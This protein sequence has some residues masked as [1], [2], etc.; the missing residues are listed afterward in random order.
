M[1]FEDNFFKKKIVQSK[2]TKNVLTL[3]VGTT[4][5][6]GITIGLSPIL[7]RIFTPSDFGL[8]ALYGAL[9]STLSVI[10]TLR[11]ELSILQPESN[12]DAHALLWL[13]ILVSLFISVILFFLVLIFNNTIVNFLNAPAISG[14]LY[15]LPFSVLLRGFYQAFNYANIRHEKFK[16]VSTAQVSQ[17][18]SGATSQLSFGFFSL[19][20]GLI[21]GQFFGL[22]VAVLV[23]FKKSLSKKIFRPTFFS[24]SKIL[25]NAKTYKKF[26]FFSTLGAFSNSFSEQIP[27]LV[28]THYFES[29]ITGV[30][31]LTIRVLSLPMTLIAQ[32]LSQVFYQKISSMKHQE[33]E[34]IKFETIK[35]MLILFLMMV[36]FV[37]I[38]SLFGEPLFAFVFGEPWREAGSMAS[39]LVF[40]VAVRLPVSTLST[41]LALDETL[42]LGVLWQVLYLLTI[43]GTLFYFSKSPL[44]IFLYAYVA[45]EIL[46]S[47][48]YG[49][50]IFKGSSL[51]SKSCNS[52]S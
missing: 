9:V 39:I 35:L 23:F 14:W 33:S 7:T 43:S 13:S 11:Y 34:L 22:L 5:A 20:G 16:T 31:S 1:N 3:M 41:V 12:D 27:I 38:M 17:S 8:L 42:K 45:H 50:F 44:E 30:F 40:A 49:F 46:Q 48:L 19:S 51:L 18:L 24:Q 25:L 26:P 21:W 36:P 2:F 37:I 29:S 32:A 52:N 47:F 28:L 10:S 15:L 6:Q 4:L